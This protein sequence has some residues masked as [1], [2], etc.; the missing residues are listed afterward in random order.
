MDKNA[1][2]DDCSLNKGSVR[3]NI[4]V[5]NQAGVNDSNF[6]GKFVMVLPGS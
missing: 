4:G 1:T 5:E 3:M 2:C 6:R